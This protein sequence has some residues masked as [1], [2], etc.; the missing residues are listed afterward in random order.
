MIIKA[1]IYTKGVKNNEDILD[2]T[3]ILQDFTHV[4]KIKYGQFSLVLGN[5]QFLTQLSELLPL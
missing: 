4:N 2:F 3:Q 1:L 5:A